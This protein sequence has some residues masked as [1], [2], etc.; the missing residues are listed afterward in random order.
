MKQQIVYNLEEFA[1]KYHLT[2]IYGALWHH[3]T[4]E[5]VNERRNESLFLRDIS[6]PFIPRYRIS[7]YIDINWKGDHKFEWAYVVHKDA[8]PKSIKKKLG[9]K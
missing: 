8:L 1:A 3:H 4:E 7:N 2:D 9:I 6:N 5:P